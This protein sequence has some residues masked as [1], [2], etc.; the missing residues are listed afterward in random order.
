M[1]KLYFRSCHISFNTI[2]ILMEFRF[3]FCGEYILIYTWYI[4]VIDTLLTQHHCNLF[5]VLQ[6]SLHVIIHLRGR[7]TSLTDRITST[8]SIWASKIYF[9]SESHPEQMC[10]NIVYS[11]NHAF[12][13]WFYLFRSI[14]D[15]RSRKLNWRATL[16]YIERATHP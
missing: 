9:R 5:W 15:V 6:Y 3:F 2:V 8:E 7:C 11:G 10:S 14:S 4:K 12:V 1:S 16:C 13:T